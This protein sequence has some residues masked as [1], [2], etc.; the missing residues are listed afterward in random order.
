MKP[1]R[2]SVEQ[3]SQL[4][5]LCLRRTI[6]EEYLDLNNHMNM[7]WYVALF[8]DAGD[9]LHDHIGLSREF[10]RATGAGTMDLEHHT[11]FINEVMAGNQICI[12]TRH[13]GPLGQDDPLPDVH[14]QRVDQ[15]SGRPLR[16][17]QRPGR[18]RGP[19]DHPLPRRN[20]SSASTPCSPNKSNFPGRRRYAAPCGC[21]IRDKRPVIG[22]GGAASIFGRRE[23]GISNYHRGG[24]SFDAVLA[25]AA[26]ESAW[27]MNLT[28]Q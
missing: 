17:C 3:V 9:T 16:M 20:L 7:R 28:I 27:Q 22:R 10:R 25:R 24:L 18:P 21:S 23:S 19:Q 12:T 4:Q 26:V 8:D 1:E 11:W 6:P 2:I 5:P 13:G 14:G 15:K